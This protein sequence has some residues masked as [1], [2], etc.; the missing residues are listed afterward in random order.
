MPLFLL[1]I[2]FAFHSEAL[3]GE[4]IK[5]VTTIPTL[6]DFVK[7]VGGEKVE[8]ISLLK[9]GEDLHTFDPRPSDTRAVYNAGILIKI[10]IGLDNWADKV[11]TASGNKKLTVIEASTGVNV[12]SSPDENPSHSHGNPHIWHDPENAKIMVEN[13]YQSLIRVSPAHA[14]YFKANRDTYMAGLTE[15]NKE[16][17]SSL[18]EIQDRRVVTYHPGWGYLLNRF[19]LRE[20]FS[21]EKAPGREPSAREIAEAIDRIRTEKVKLILGEPEAPKK[22]LG[23]ISR[24]SGAMAVN[25]APEIGSLP[26]IG[27]YI[28]MMRYNVG[29]IARGLK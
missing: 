24:E 21:I 6:K 17:D 4:K 22:M 15:L 18:S 23:I 16:L 12:L 9:G 27:S 1:A 7:Q 19:H 3:A 14:G 25:L 28:E 5:V 8:V 10:G 2:L 11:A 13:I 29:E 20:L 26:E